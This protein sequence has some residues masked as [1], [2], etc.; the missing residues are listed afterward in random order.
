ME[1]LL[2]ILLALMAGAGLPL[3]AS[4]NSAMRL[5]LGRPEWA[6]LVNFVV[7]SMG[8]ALYVALQRLPLPAAAAWGRA[9]W[10]AW[11]GGLLG[12]FYVTATVVLTPR[13]GV[14][15]S[16]AL[17]LAGQVMAALAFDHFGLLGLVERA[18]TP[19]RALGALLLVAGVI[20][21]QR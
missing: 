1:L 15:T 4:V 12:A 9:P 13:L 11:S 18:V 16:L 10:W 3:Q 8:L 7:G 17:M 6:A 21:V 2:L 19:T 14:T 20:L 5:Q